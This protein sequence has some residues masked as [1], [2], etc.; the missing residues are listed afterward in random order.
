MGKRYSGG[1]GGPGGASR[2][3]GARGRRGQAWLRPKEE[4]TADDSEGVEAAILFRIEP[5]MDTNEREWLP[6][7]DGG[8]FRRE[9]GGRGLTTEGHGGRQPGKR[10]ASADGNHE[11]GRR[12]SRRMES[13]LRIHKVSATIGEAAGGRVGQIQRTNS[14]TDYSFRWCFHNH[15]LVVRFGVEAAPRMGLFRC[16]AI[17]RV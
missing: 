6:M 11:H 14:G 17:G 2:R 3:S 10:E 15:G 1:V 16:R 12:P 8:R 13:T 7:H 4:Y 9:H 5:R